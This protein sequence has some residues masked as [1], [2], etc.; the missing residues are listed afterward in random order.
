MCAIFE[1]LR[2]LS[3][4]NNMLARGLI[5][6]I[7]FGGTLVLFGFG[8]YHRYKLII[9]PA[10]KEERRKYNIQ[11]SLEF[12]RKVQDKIDEKKASP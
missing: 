6:P 1:S 12:H 5:F 10:E 2:A 3:K 7:V 9:N 8:F 4:S 11:Q